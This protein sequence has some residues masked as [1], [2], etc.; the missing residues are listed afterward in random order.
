MNYQF[1]NGL[2]EINQYDE[3]KTFSSF[4]PGLAG[5]KGIPLWAYYVNRGQGISSF[6]VRDKNGAILEFYPANLAYMYVP[7]IG[8]RTFIKNNGQVFEPFQ[9]KLHQNSR[10]MMIEP[11]SLHLEEVISEL[12][13]RVKVSYFGLPGE[14]IAGLVRRVEIENQS[15]K[16]MDLEMLDGIAQILPSGIGYGDYK[17][18]SN[19]LRSWMNVDNLE[20]QI[21]FYK[22]R[23]ST[24]DEAEMK[25]MRSGNFYASYVDHHLTTPITDMDLVFGYDTSLQNARKFEQTPLSE[26]TSFPQYTEN[27]VPCGFTPASFTMKPGEIHHIDTIIGYTENIEIVNVKRMLFEEVSY[28]EKKQQEAKQVIDV[29][30]KD[31]SSKTNFPIFDEYIKQTYLD[32]LLRGGYPM[33]IHTDKQDFTYY[34]Y[35]RKHGD[36]ERDYNFFTLAPEF[37]SQGNGN[38]RDVCQN[39][40][41][42]IFFHPEVGS[43]NVDVFASLIQAD[44][45]NPLG[46][47][48]ATFELLD[49]TLSKE[50][51]LQIFGKS[52]DEFIKHLQGKFTPGSIINLI[53]RLKLETSY[54]DHEIFS[55]VFDHAKQ[56]IEASFNEGY[57]SD[58]WTYILDLIENYEHIFP[59]KMD[60]MLYEKE[61]I[62]I[63]Q[64]PVSVYPRKEKTVL[65]QS[66]NVRQYGSTRHPDHQMIS[67]FKMNEHGT[68]WFK[69]Q[70]GKEISINLMSK[71]LILAINK[72][73]LLDPE[74]LGIEMEGNKPGWNDAMNGLPG[75]F[76]SGMSET[77]ELARLVTFIQKHIKIDT[78]LSFPVEFIDFVE[79]IKDVKSNDSFTYWDE[80]STKREVY[81]EQIRI[82]SQGVK[83][84]QS[85][86]V[87]DFVNQMKHKLDESIQR[88]MAIGNGIIPT[89][90]YYEATAYDHYV[91]ASN[92]PIIGH[93]KLPLVKV[94]SFTRKQLPNFL[95]APARFLKYN[96]NQAQNQAMIQQIKQTGIYDDVLKMYKTSDDLNDFGFEIGRIRAFT[97]GW[98]EREANFLHMTYKYLLGILKAGEVATFLEEAK[99]NLVCFMDPEVYGRSTLENS[100]FIA[101]S[102][103]PNP[104]LHGQGF[105]SRLTGSTSEMISI[106]TY[107]LYGDKLFFMK[108]NALHLELKPKVPASFFL[109]NQIEVS[110]LQ[111]K[112]TYHLENETYQG[113]RSY[114][115]IDQ[116]G[117]ETEIQG[118]DIPED[119]ALLVRSQK[120]KE[121]HVNLS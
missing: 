60:Q 53:H 83:Y 54:Q 24:G 19:L 110:F 58:H 84:V 10:K 8:F 57:W 107:L 103:N 23:S 77:I 25:E 109:N 90:F 101:T 79:A 108:D 105:V 31:V 14:D 119:Y 61:T 78:M 9:G 59:D 65:D 22:L 113:V 47:N 99:T 2:F 4:L 100:S 44:G 67:N 50:I 106:W 52:N 37:Y 43:Y 114:R 28:F 98:L 69:D 20:N 26:L 96:K 56:N 63:Y 64:S 75:L 87:V 112:V 38:F 32:N 97:K 121:I 86:C 29:L 73:A 92:Q 89:Y 70:T 55:I 76:G 40:R 74:G 6:G 91:D 30:L 1:K 36:L 116:N 45:Y 12:G 115:L 93:Y 102:N 85:N 16:L 49:P 48:G 104:Y 111:T 3:Q 15:A 80:V 41:S 39:R 18:I 27:K 88:A 72:F 51:C 17:A 82:P 11:S 35:S 118:S 7:Q 33:N 34:L 95:E 46:I 5:P 117:L 68:N 66:G 13:L 42:D 21:P 71:L 81:R 94:K 120:I 62:K